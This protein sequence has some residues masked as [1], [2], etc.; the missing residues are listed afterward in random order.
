MNSTQ[1]SDRFKKLVHD[2]IHT[3]AIPFDIS[4]NNLYD[5]IYLNVLS[6][7]EDDD[8]RFNL[9]Q[10]FDNLYYTHYAASTR[11][12]FWPKFVNAAISVENPDRLLK[13]PCPR[14]GAIMSGLELKRYIL[15]GVMT[16]EV[17]GSINYICPNLGLEN[18][19]NTLNSFKHGLSAQCQQ[20]Y[21][22]H[23]L[24]N[25]V[26]GASGYHSIDYHL[27]TIDIKTLNT[28]QLSYLI[29][30]VSRVITSI[31]FID[32]PSTLQDILNDLNILFN[33][34]P[35][36]PAF[37]NSAVQLES[38]TLLDLF[39]YSAVSKHMALSTYSEPTAALPELEF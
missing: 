5:P 27:S 23:M 10:S 19:N 25:E 39:N 37:K 9:M 33:E 17:F 21:L 15:N 11:T 22:T 34:H 3:G 26:N 8:I 2:M 20:D 6:F 31:A 24:N 36:W 4:Q 7:V 13:P 16:D 35:A 30:N 1:K 28:K 18:F 14:W 12:E 32:T 38:I 29:T